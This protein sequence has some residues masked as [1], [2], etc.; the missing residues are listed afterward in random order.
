MDTT[1]MKLTKVGHRCDNFLCSRKSDKLL[2]HC[3][4]CRTTISP[5]VSSCDTAAC[6]IAH[7]P[8]RSVTAGDQ[9]RHT[10]GQ[11]LII[12]LLARWLQ[13][14]G[15]GTMEKDFQ[16]NWGGPQLNFFIKLV[17]E[18]SCFINNMIWEQLTYSPIIHTSLPGVNKTVH[19]CGR[20]AGKL[21]WREV[22]GA[23][24]AIYNEE[25]T[26]IWRGKI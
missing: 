9:P 17:K 15:N 16:N 23:Q 12:E 6:A 25:N 3:I 11:S 26:G 22:R 7:A 5:A 4:E 1:M 21:L 13:R 10:V 2:H 24:G 20:H 8:H 19:G 18:T 14:F